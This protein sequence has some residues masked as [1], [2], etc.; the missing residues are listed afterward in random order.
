MD[1]FEDSEQQ[2]DPQQ[3]AYAKLHI[4]VKSA[5]HPQRNR[6]NVLSAPAPREY[7]QGRSGHRQK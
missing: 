2:I 3:W 1:S 4:L 6:P 7:W 5:A